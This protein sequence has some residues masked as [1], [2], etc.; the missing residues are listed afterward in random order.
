M[1]SPRSRDFF[2]L[3]WEDELFILMSISDA[4]GHVKR[5]ACA[6]LLVIAEGLLEG[7]LTIILQLCSPR[8]SELISWYFISQNNVC[9]AMGLHSV[10]LCLINQLDDQLGFVVLLASL[11][12]RARGRVV[13]TLF[14]WHFIYLLQLNAK[15]HIREM[16]KNCFH[17]G[18]SSVSA[19][20]I[21]FSWCLTWDYL[22]WSGH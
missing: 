16:V 15:G 3:H 11:T 13:N 17:T 20:K 9:R 4:L 7:L 18:A 2:M 21:S 22:F 8:V 6:F 5:P 14:P 12:S 1:Q 19:Q 10:I